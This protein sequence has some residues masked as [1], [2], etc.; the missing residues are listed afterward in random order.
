VDSDEI[1][2]KPLFEVI[3]EQAAP[4]DAEQMIWA[5]EHVLAAA[6]IDPFLLDHFA[7]AAVCAL[8]YRDGE[9]PRH[10]IELLYRRAIDDERWRSEYAQLLS[11]P[12]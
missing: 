1:D 11:M 5:L 12:S 3:R 8:A 6:R 10:M 9:T 4:A 7:V 2:T